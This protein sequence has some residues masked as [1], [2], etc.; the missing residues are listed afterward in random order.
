MNH[1][2]D[3][4]WNAIT[5]LVKNHHLVKCNQNEVKSSPITAAAPILVGGILVDVIKY[6]YVP[7]LCRSP[8]LSTTRNLSELLTLWG[9]NCLLERIF[10]NPFQFYFHELHAVS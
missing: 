6:R 9:S 1:Y 3:I 2:G 5:Y 4:L 10:M 7:D 8:E